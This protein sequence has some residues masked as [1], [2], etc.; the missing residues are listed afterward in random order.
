MVLFGF[1]ALLCVGAIIL[2]LKNHPAYY[3]AYAIALS[4]GLICVCALKGEKPR[5]RWG[6]VQP[7]TEDES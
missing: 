5:W 7:G 2:P 6:K 1:C 4:A 3:V